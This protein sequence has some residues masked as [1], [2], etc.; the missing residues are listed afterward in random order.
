MIQRNHIACAVLL[1]VKMTAIT[2]KAFITVY[3]IKKNLLSDYLRQ[4]LRSPS[5]RMSLRKS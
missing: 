5:V 3:Q 2:R 1:W 4:E